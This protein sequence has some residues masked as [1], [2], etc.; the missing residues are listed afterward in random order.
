MRTSPLTDLTAASLSI[1]PFTATSPEAVFSSSSRI[2]PRITV[3]AEAVST[4][5]RLP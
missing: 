1:S 3:S 4:P 2:R 5:G